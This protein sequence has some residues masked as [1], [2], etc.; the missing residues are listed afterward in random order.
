MNRLDR[1][2]AILVQLQSR[3]VVRASDCAE[4][5]GVSLRTIYRDMRTL[6]GAGVP[7]CGDAG[8]GYSLIDGYRL[9]PLMF[10][11]EEA[12][13][14]LTAEKLIERLTDS[15]NS[16]HFRSGMDKIR[17]VMRGV[18][19]GYLESIDRSIEVHHDSQAIRPGVL[20]T[21]LRSIH[22]REILTMEYTRGDGSQ[23]TRR[24]EAVGMTYLHPR[25]YMA[26][27]CHS[28]GEYRTF[29]LDRIDSLTGLG[30]THSIDHPPFAE[31]HLNFFKN[32]NTMK[33]N[34]IE[35]KTLE[36]IEVIS[37]THKGDYSG[38]PALFN[39]MDEWAGANNYWRLA[40]RMLGIYH[41]DP[42]DTPPAELLSSAALEARPGMELGEGM[43]RYTVSGGK[44]LVMNA[45]VAM[46]EYTEAWQ[47]IYS[48]I[49]QRG[50]KD[51]D[52]DH[53]ELYVS[54]TDSSQGND[55]PWI[56]DFCV[57]VV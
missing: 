43:K 26:A 8:V 39:R 49:A 48:E 54:C 51:D 53:Y 56:V 52:R 37:L 35:I 55:A 15:H 12:I 6:E 13:A 31:L 24:V 36:S 20:Q 27:W 41:N 16:A 40:P 14:M 21:I 4:R 3:S 57:P 42:T 7:L 11:P 18:P 28:R 50:L 10:S 29:R 30:Q 33:V 46:S 25:W 1:I 38:I 22:A 34:S 19:R 5:F 44:Y 2:S 17:A 23:S 47:R 45:E 32:H 9:P